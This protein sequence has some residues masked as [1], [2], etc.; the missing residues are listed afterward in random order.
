MF[1]FRPFPSKLKQMLDRNGNVE[2]H[3]NKSTG[4]VNIP[5]APETFHFHKHYRD[6][7]SVQRRRNKVNDDEI[8]EKNGN[9][10]DIL[11]PHHEF[12][13][14][15]DVIEKP[16]LSRPPRGILHNEKDPSR[17]FC[18]VVESK[19]RITFNNVVVREYEMVLG[20]HPDCSYGPP[21]SIGWD[22]LEYKPVDINDYETNHSRRRPLRY[23]M[24]N[25]YRRKDILKDVNEDDLKKVVRE[26]KR[27][28]MLRQITRQFVMFWKLEDGM[29]SACRKAKRLI[30][31]D[32]PSAWMPEDELDWS[33]DSKSPIL[34]K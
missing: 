17:H 29:E 4:F 22:Y 6:T 3:K 33:R 12:R 5:R 1:A 14:E 25:Y 34:K 11:I 13:V 2:V 16:I 26:V 15:E 7:V 21:V 10:E 24:L 20:D 23:L 18:E 27:V 32:P 9:L 30:K 8:H 19:R 28:Y 31:K